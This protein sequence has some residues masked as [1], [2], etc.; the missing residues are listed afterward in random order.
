MT[1]NQL[2]N[3]IKESA[4][5]MNT[6]DSL[7]PEQISK[8]LRHTNPT[9]S[10]RHLSFWR[11]ASAAAVLLL[12][13]ILSQIAWNTNR[14]K[15]DTEIS[16]SNSFQE[17]KNTSPSDSVP[18]AESSSPTDSKQDAGTL[19][20]VAKSYEQIYDVLENSAQSYHFSMRKASELYMESAIAEDAADGDS[21][22]TAGKTESKQVYSKTNLQTEGVD[23][24]DFVKTDGR[25][26][27]TVSEQEIKI[28]DTADGALKLAGTIHPDINVSDSVLE[29][30]VDNGTLLLLVQKYDT[31]LETTEEDLEDTAEANYIQTNESTVV[32]T[33]DI[34]NPLEAKLIGTLKQDGCYNTSRK[35]GD[36]LYLFT[37]KGPYYYAS[38]E[39]LA[40]DEQIP[41]INDEK[42]PANHIYLPE[43]G[44]QSSLILSSVN[45]RQPKEII[46]EIMIINENATVYVGSDSLYLYH[47]DYRS[48]DTLTQIAKFDIENGQIN[49]VN[50]AAVR[51]EIYDTFAI[52]EYRNTLR[53]LTTSI[54]NADTSNNL[55]LFDENMTLTGTLPSIAVGEEIYAARFF[56]N[57]AYFITYRNT[58]PL[59]AADLS[60]PANPILLGELEISGFSDYLHFWSDDKLL[61]I[62]Y[63]TDPETGWQ[64]GVK[65][66]MFD[67][68]NPV[69]LKTID[70]L[71][72]DE[73]YYTPACNDYKSVLADSNQNLIGFAAHFEPAKDGC[74]VGYNVYSWEDNHFVKKLSSPRD[75]PSDTIR[76]IYIGNHFYIASPTEI[77]SFNME[78]DFKEG[79]TLIFKKQL[80]E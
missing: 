53:V 12:C 41:S 33:Y 68:S 29:L 23:E 16:E 17:E 59:F 76:G 74:Y 80:I 78:N 27:Y 75:I 51:G 21:A 48:N 77:T 9:H 45:I 42:I 25:Y 44:G 79:S 72:L 37:Q 40:R 11:I 63:E 52:N 46:D 55:F 57:T 54:E 50:A 60:D 67:I 35:I 43:E 20:S 2:L 71:V 69:E 4:G 7:T 1:D 24:S 22:N 32:Y 70:S 5:Q 19:Y 56:E 26:I 62:G 30:Y 49:A 61:G 64:K 65:L 14:L 38:P 58:D 36:I 15:P 6:P 31:S 47:T 34:A 8:R 3:L 28:T 13:G 10:F 66:V 39:Y 73:Y 18:P